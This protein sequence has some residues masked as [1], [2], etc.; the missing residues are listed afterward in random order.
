MERRSTSLAAGALAAALLAGGCSDP[1]A[2]SKA[3]FAKALAPVVADR[4]CSTLRLSDL[5]TNPDT[6]APVPAFPIVLPAEPAPYGDE[7]RAELEAGARAGL[8]SRTERVQPATTLGLPGALKPTDTISYA[9]TAAGSAA[10]RP[11]MAFDT[12]FR[13]RP[14]PAA[15]KATGKVAAVVR[16]TDPASEE[17]QTISKVTYRYIGVD[18][19]PLATREDLGRMAQPAEDTAVM[20]RT[21]DGWQPAK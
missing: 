14:F 11:I 4:F 10:F 1:K 6:S 20:V 8:L 12:N 16:W 5:I 2:A 19:T 15:C 17:G 9:P 13:K 3:N 21:S 7:D 18:P